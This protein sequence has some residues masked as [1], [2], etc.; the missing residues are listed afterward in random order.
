MGFLQV[1]DMGLDPYTPIIYLITH[2]YLK[3]HGT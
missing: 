2:P 3:A 1:K